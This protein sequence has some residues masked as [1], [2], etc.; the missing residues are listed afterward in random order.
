MKAR[1]PSCSRGNTS[2]FAESSRFPACLPKLHSFCRARIDL[3]ST[4]RHNKEKR[5]HELT[6]QIV[7]S[8]NVF[9][10]FPKAWNMQKYAK[11]K[12]KK[13]K[14]HRCLF[15]CFL[16]RR[17]ACEE[18]ETM[19]SSFSVLFFFSWWCF[20]WQGLLSCDNYIFKRE[21]KEYPF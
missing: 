3:V 19:R 13:R 14:A 9:P 16:S 12:K 17:T 20:S 2:F 6:G 8:L 10:L 15:F 1:M 5:K 11:K 7:S 21:I 4:Q 18:I